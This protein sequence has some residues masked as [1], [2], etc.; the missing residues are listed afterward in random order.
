MSTT[1][2]AVDMP[3]CASGTTACS[4]VPSPSAREL[5]VLVLVLVLVLVVLRRDDRTQARGANVRDITS[6]MLGLSAKR[7]ACRTAMPSTADRV[8]CTRLGAAI[9]GETSALLA[10]ALVAAAALRLGLGLAGHICPSDW[11]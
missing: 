3:R 7:R 11:L 5:F 2:S 4:M 8:S 9:T 6:V 10:A 1:C